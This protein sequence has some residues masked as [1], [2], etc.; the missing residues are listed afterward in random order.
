METPYGNLSLSWDYCLIVIQLP[1]YC[2][3]S[4]DPVWELLTGD[5]VAFLRMYNRYTWL[6]EQSKQLLTSHISI[7]T[8]SGYQQLKEKQAIFSLILAAAH[9]TKSTGQAFGNKLQDGVYGLLYGM[10]MERS[11]IG[12][13][14]YTPASDQFQ[15]LVHGYYFLKSH[16]SRVNSI[17]N[18]ITD[19]WGITPSFIKG[20]TFIQ[21]QRHYI[22]TGIRDSNKADMTALV[23]RNSRQEAMQYVLINMIMWVS[24]GWDRCVAID[25]STNHLHEQVEYLYTL[26]GC[27]I[28]FSPHYWRVQHTSSISVSILREKVYWH[29]RHNILRC[30]CTGS[31]DH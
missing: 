13:S 30:F 14:S 31:P 2:L 22:L 15:D 21:R 5:C 23:V 29:T 4:I 24:W 8:F 3:L 28:N 9:K 1:P 17:E 11:Y 7:P 25:K 18:A 12:F 19:A 6:P 10:M 27:Y 26:N 16:N 20:W